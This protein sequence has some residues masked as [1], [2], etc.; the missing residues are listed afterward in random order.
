MTNKYSLKRFKVHFCTNLRNL[1]KQRT[2][3][4]CKHYLMH[5]IYLAFYLKSKIYVKHIQFWSQRDS[6][7]IL[8]YFNFNKIKVFEFLN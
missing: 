2:C 1:Y 6:N 3:T 8:L 5:M 4:P 7:L